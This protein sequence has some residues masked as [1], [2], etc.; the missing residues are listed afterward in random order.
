MIADGISDD[1]SPQ[2]NIL[3][4]VIPILKHFCACLHFKSFF[5]VSNW[6]V[7]SHMKQHVTQ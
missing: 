7:P 1:V 6:R 4:M 5:V 2:I 3:N